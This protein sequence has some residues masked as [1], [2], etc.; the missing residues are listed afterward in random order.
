MGAAEEYFTEPSASEEC[1][2]DP[3]FL[4]E[5]RGLNKQAITKNTHNTVNQ[6][7]LEVIAGS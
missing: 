7:K 4:R 5:S 2:C 3:V 1:C 6:S